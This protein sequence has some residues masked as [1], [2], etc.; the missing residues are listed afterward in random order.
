MEIR[1]T[2]GAHKIAQQIS[3]S[4]HFALNGNPPSTLKRFHGIDTERGL[5]S[6]FNCFIKGELT[7][8]PTNVFFYIFQF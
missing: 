2:N 8:K 5:S 6:Q 1:N 3:S 7:S 4:Q